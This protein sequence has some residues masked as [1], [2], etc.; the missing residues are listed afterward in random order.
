M[1][2]MAPLIKAEVDLKLNWYLLFN[3][4][5]A[6]VNCTL[7]VFYSGNC[8]PS[9]VK[10]VSKSIGVRN[11][12]RVNLQVSGSSAVSLLTLIALREN[13]LSPTTELQ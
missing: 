3:L 12:T 7:S 5:L 4:L 2:E 11:A 1:T 8:P 9:L 13:F 10:R 6:L